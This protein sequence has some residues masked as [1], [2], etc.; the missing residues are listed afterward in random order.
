MTHGKG[1]I[2][3]FWQNR[4]FWHYLVVWGARVLVLVVQYA[5]LKTTGS[6]EGFYVIFLLY[7]RISNTISFFN[8]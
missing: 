7:L 6:L 5:T 2:G 8:A 4:P 3:I 1:I